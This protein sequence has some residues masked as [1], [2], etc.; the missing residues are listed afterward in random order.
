MEQVALLKP[1]DKFGITGKGLVIMA[2]IK[3]GNVMIGNVIEFKCDDVKYRR[4][5]IGI[6]IIRRASL[7]NP[8]PENMKEPAIGAL[9]ETENDK[10]WLKLK[11][12]K[13]N[14]DIAIV[15]KD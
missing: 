1:E 4:K 12:A 15:Y 7:F 8:I 13:L 3:E 14:R 11:E 2:I 9:V 10:E 6:E 5:V